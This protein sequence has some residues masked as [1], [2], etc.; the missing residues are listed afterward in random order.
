MNHRHIK[1]SGSLNSGKQRHY[2]S[3]LIILSLIGLCVFC[4]RVDAQQTIPE[5]IDLRPGFVGVRYVL[6]LVSLLP[7]GAPRV[8]W[9]LVCGGT[10]IGGAKLE[11]PRG[12]SLINL[13][14]STRAVVG[15][16]LLV[17]PIAEDVLADRTDPGKGRRNAPYTFEV[18]GTYD[19]RASTSIRFRLPVKPLGVDET[20]FRPI[21][22]D[23]RR[24]TDENDLRNIVVGF[25]PARV[26]PP[27]PPAPAAP[28]PFVLVKS[29]SDQETLAL[30]EVLDDTF[31]PTTVIQNDQTNR[32]NFVIK[33]ADVAPLVAATLSKDSTT[34]FEKGDY[35]VVHIIRWKP[36][37][38]EKSDPERELWALFEKINKRQIDG[39]EYEWLPHFLASEKGKLQE[40][41]IYD[42]RIFGS[43]R[44]YIL[45]IHLNT[46]NSWDIKY[47]LNI[48]QQI[49]TP[50]QNALLLATTILGGGGPGLAGELPQTKDIWGARLMLFR[51]SASDMIV[52]VNAVT[53][54]SDIQ[55]NQQN[56]DYSNKFVNEGRYW[57]DISVGMP[58]NSIKELEYTVDTT[59]QNNV[60]SVK[61]KE[62][63]NAY[64]FLNLFPMK[65]DLQANSFLTK[66]HFVLGVP[67]S[68][69][70]LDRPIVGVGTGVYRDFF[71]INFF[72]GV[73]FN[74]VRQPSTLQVGSQSTEGE[75]EADLRTKRQAKFVF[76]INFPVR[77]FVT[78][79]KNDKK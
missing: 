21:T 52:Q 30:T 3:A 8:D 51:Y 24:P 31:D 16:G 37:K 67:I 38:D 15:Q 54:T 6:P 32:A 46:P 36:L 39:H 77:Q 48:N 65:V 10:G 5:T 19:N 2:A 58:A 59:G 73:A 64:G 69:K 66:P 45:P 57:W 20:R 42:T 25:T 35:L 56:K 9:R 43:K 55:V 18:V 12:L 17:E 60:V 72:A 33:D 63:Q 23:D 78:A 61:K 13:E 11:C 68:G 49:P 74:K 40:K 47:K 7:A 44:V 14:D 53:P 62:R 71:K 26:V 4:F 29:T 41:R 75:L 70:P 50:I 79:L 28:P 1:T 22:A 27:P 34:V 76:G